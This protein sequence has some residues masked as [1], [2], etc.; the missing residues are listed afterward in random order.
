[1]YLTSANLPRGILSSMGPALAGSDHPTLAMAVMV[2]VGFTAF[3]LICLGPSSSAATLTQGNNFE[4]YLQQYYF[5]TM[6]SAPLV[7]Q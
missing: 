2:T 5:V 6:S 3:T 7:A 4:N 1:M